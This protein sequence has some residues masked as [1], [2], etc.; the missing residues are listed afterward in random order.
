M[1]LKI[2]CCCFLPQ[3]I[4]RGECVYRD[5]TL[6]ILELTTRDMM[7]VQFYSPIYCVLRYVHTYILIPNIA[8][9]IHAYMHIDF[10]SKLGL[11]FKDGMEWSNC[12]LAVCA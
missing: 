1:N 2:D 10:I 4:A 3:E 7:E 6:V 12:C 5:D 8:C 9:I 11:K